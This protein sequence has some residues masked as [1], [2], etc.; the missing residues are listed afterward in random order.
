MPQKVL[1]KLLSYDLAIANSPQNVWLHALLHTLLILQMLLDFGTLCTI[2]AKERR[3]KYVWRY[4]VEVQMNHS[5][6][7]WLAS[8]A[9]LMVRNPYEEALL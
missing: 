9:P 8:Q 4:S 1:I 5:R 6:C 3:W 7:R 2:S